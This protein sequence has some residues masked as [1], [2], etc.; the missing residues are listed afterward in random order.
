MFGLKSLFKDNDNPELATSILQT[1]QVLGDLTAGDQFEAHRRLVSALAL[2][3]KSNEPLTRDRLKQLIHYDH[4]GRALQRELS[5]RYFSNPDHFKQ[6]EEALWKQIFALYWLLAHCYQAFVRNYFDSKGK[7]DF[8]PYLA[9]ITV[10]ALHFFRMQIKWNYFQGKAIDPSMWKRLHSLY[11]ISEVGGFAHKEV[12]FNS[13]E[14]LGTCHDEYVRVL[15]V[16]LLSPTELLP[17]QLDT[18]D[19]WMAGWTGLITLHQDRS[20]R[21]NTHCVDLALGFGAARLGQEEQHPKHRY[22]QMADLVTAVYRSKTE[23]QAHL[24]NPTITPEERLRHDADLDLIDRV[25]RLWMR[26]APKREQ[27]IPMAA[28]PAIRCHTAAVAA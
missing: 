1:R 13:G 10:R 28:K 3:H 27:E 20:T 2:F 14:Q 23:M 4:A 16:E 12:K 24:Q 26:P 7:S 22:W 9:L 5:Q 6:G 21:I 8:A 15:V 17:S 18:I 25:V 11:R 19:G